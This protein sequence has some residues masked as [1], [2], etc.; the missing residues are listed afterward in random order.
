[1][2]AALLEAPARPGAP[3]VPL[4]APE[5]LDK[6]ASLGSPDAIALFLTEQGIKATPS[7]S[8]TCAIALYLRRELDTEFLAVGTGSMVIWTRTCDGPDMHHRLPAPVS[9][10]IM[11][12]DDL[13]YPELIDWAGRDQR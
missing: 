12:F 6:L 3:A 13:Y 2:T 10:F 4:T 1:M 9:Q 11:R 5:L 7:R 8:S